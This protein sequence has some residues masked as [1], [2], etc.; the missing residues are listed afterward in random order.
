MKN[1]ILALF[2]SISEML[3]EIGKMTD[4]R[5]AIED[6][7]AALA[8]ILNQLNKEE[9]SLQRSKQKLLE[10]QAEFAALYSDASLINNIAIKTLDQQVEV[11]REIVA[12]EIKPKLKIVFFPYKASM[13]D[14]LETIYEAAAI[15]PDC[16]AKVVPIPYYQIAG[17]KEIPTYEGNQF[18]AHIP[19]THYNEYDLAYEEPDVIYVH[20]IYDQYNTITRVHEVFFTSNLKQYTGMLVYVPYHISSFIAPSEGEKSLAYNIPTIHNVDRVVLVNDT[21]KEAAIRDGV[22]KEKLLV[23]GTP[24]LDGMLRALRSNEQAYP[25][26]WKERV[27]GKKVFVFETPCLMFAQNFFQ[28][29]EKMMEI[30]NLPHMV[31]NSIL[32]WRPHPLTE[33]SIYKYTP[34]FS[35]YYTNLIRSIKEGDSLYSHIIFDESP[36]YFSALK[37]ADMLIT[38]G[39]SLLSAY[40]L[41]EKPILYWGGQLPEGSLITNDAFYYTV[42]RELPAPEVAKMIGRGEDPCAHHRKGLASSVYVNADGT[43]GVKIYQAIKDSLLV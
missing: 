12:A 31:D 41:T 42:N 16:E 22:P 34:V 37:V 15:D 13:W 21:L 40:L 7:S 25:E 19:I 2:G 1:K 32:I 36:D 30:F 8:A 3:A 9:S 38:C 6:C 35:E 5:R 29:F 43:S 4:K 18:P 27:K 17:D 23:L 11:L 26:E 14:S 39:G 33:A 28:R 10:I 20:N 24:K